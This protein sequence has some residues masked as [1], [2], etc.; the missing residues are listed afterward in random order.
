MT[1]PMNILGAIR[2]EQRKLEKQA[3]ELQGPLERLG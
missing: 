1:S 2:R 3:G